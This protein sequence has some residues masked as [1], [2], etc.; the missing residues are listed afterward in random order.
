MSEAKLD[1]T[2]RARQ[3]R[4]LPSWDEALAY[5]KKH[6]EWPWSSRHKKGKDARK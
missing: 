3:E 4:E 1:A 2:I 6:G 5:L